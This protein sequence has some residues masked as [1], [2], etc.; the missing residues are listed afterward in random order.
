MM[1]LTYGHGTESA[2]RRAAILTGADVSEPD[3]VSG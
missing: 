1:L 2:E 3:D